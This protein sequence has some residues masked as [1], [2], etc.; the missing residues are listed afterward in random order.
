MQHGERLLYRQLEPN[1]LL[2]A[3]HAAMRAR[4]WS[5]LQANNATFQVVAMAT[6]CPRTNS[7]SSVT[8]QAASQAFTAV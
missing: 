1:V 5:A 6:V 7:V 3:P 2:R 8:R 4:T